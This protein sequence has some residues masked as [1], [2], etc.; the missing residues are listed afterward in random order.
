MANDKKDEDEIKKPIKS[1]ND[2]KPEEVKDAK[3]PLQLKRQEK[4]ERME[5]PTNMKPTK[6][7]ETDAGTNPE[8]GK[9]NNEVDVEPTLAEE[10]MSLQEILSTKG[11]RRLA[12]SA[13]KNKR[14]LQQA[15]KKRKFRRADKSRLISRARKFATRQVRSKV[16]TQ[17]AKN[18]KDLSPTAKAL[19]DRKVSKRKKAVDRLARRELPQQRIKD[20]ER[21]RRE[22][23]IPEGKTWHQLF[24]KDK[25]VKTDARF[26]QYKKPMNVDDLFNIE[27]VKEKFMTKLKADEFNESYDTLKTLV[28]N[29]GLEGMFSYLDEK[30]QDKS[31]SVSLK[32]LQDLIESDK[33]T[34]VSSHAYTVT[35]YHNSGMTPRELAD[36][37][38]EIK[39]DEH[40]SISSPSSFSHLVKR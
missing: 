36:L 23:Y 27:K 34:S 35:R 20:R 26:K 24:C 17:Q 4:K 13:R 11:R 14:R 39:L 6:K 9:I 21:T 8:V 15:R 31:L 1:H 33:S 18:Y 5:K 19:I 25:T 3:T 40:A 38:E 30:V 7:S 12:M 28:E 2:A 10:K 22:E 37:Y 29:Q 32:M 16:A